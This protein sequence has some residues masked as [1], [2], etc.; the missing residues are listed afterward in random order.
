MPWLSWS[1]AG[2]SGVLKRSKP[3]DEETIEEMARTPDATRSSVTPPI[4]VLH[5]STPGIDSRTTVGD[6]EFWKYVVGVEPIPED[7]SAPTPGMETPALATPGVEEPLVEAVVQEPLFPEPV[8]QEPLF[9]EPVAQEPL[10][11]ERVAQEPLFPEP[12]AQ[13][14]LFPEPVAPEPVFP[15]PVGPEPVFPEPVAP[16]PAQSPQ[17]QAGEGE[18]EAEKKKQAQLEKKRSNSRAW[19]AKWESKGVLK[20]PKTATATDVSEPAV[21]APRSAAS[22]SSL[23]DARDFFIKDWISHSDMEQS[24][25]RRKA[26]TKAWMES[27]LRSEAVAARA[28]VQK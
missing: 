13:E 18:D 11:P 8:A 17:Q 12:V 16:A 7:S 23:T 26:A 14:P 22:F 9:P 3:L 6:D 20:K 25:D 15:E 4:E 5:G 24:V 1:I 28:G 21:V 2:K 10:F 27:N 19:H